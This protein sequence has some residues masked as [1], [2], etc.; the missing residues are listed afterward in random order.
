MFR[1]T[2][3]TPEV[4]TTWRPTGYVPTVQSD[5]VVPVAQS[6]FVAVF[7]SIVALVGSIILVV[8]I[9][10][11]LWLPFVVGGAG[12]GLTLLRCA[13]A[14]ADQQPEDQQQTPEQRR[15][16]A[17]EHRMQLVT[18]AFS[19]GLLCGAAT[20]LFLAVAPL[21]WWTPGAV[22]ALTF[23]F[24]AAWR[25]TRAI[26]DRQQAALWR[27]EK[28][29]QVDYNHDGRIGRP[30]P[31]IIQRR[32]QGGEPTVAPPPPVD[33]PPRPASGDFYSFIVRAYQVGLTRSVWLPVNGPRHVLPSGAHVSKGTYN[34]YVKQLTEA[35]LAE[36]RGLGTLL[37]A[38]IAETMQRC[39]LL[40]LWEADGRPGTSPA[41]PP[42]RPPDQAE[43]EG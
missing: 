40:H 33:A 30:E 7:W 2:A 5:V 3:V 43:G 12:A 27:R 21:P 35:G 37:T 15:Q 1:E 28:Q 32:E 34:Y 9:S 6:L 26:E 10:W 19:A 29:D 14:G 24:L 17:R 20:I 4:E 38:P 36:D 11:P 22:A 25:V 16:Q 23:V 31:I 39:A 13:A 18:W 42:A 41:R 8:P